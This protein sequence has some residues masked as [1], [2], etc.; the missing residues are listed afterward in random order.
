MTLG[1][2]DN[3][4]ELTGDLH[5]QFGWQK[6]VETVAQ[7]YKGL[8]SEEQERAI[9]FSMGYGTAGAID[10]FGPDYG[11]PGAV[12]RDNSYYLWKVPPHLDLVLAAGVS[13]RFLD[14]VFEEIE[15]A[16]SVELENVNP[17]DSPFVVSVCRKPRL[18][19]EELW[20]QL[21]PW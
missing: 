2:F 17:W 1:L 14:Q 21:R 16:A 11:L 5:A 7:V 20:P 9:I 12:S 19:V 13:R 18:T 10:Y 3:V 4:H 8:T 15:E 6:R